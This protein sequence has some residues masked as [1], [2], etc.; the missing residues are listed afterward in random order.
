MPR[1]YVDLHFAPNWELIDPAR[2]FL[3][4]F[5]SITLRNEEIAGQVGLDP[6]TG[7]IVEGGVGAQARQVLANIS[8]VLGD[9]GASLTDVAK[10]TV[11]L[12]DMADFAKV[13]EVYTKHLGNSRPARSTVAVAGLPRGVR[14]VVLSEYGITPVRR[15]IAL[16]RVFRAR[17]WLTLKEELGRELLDCG[18]SRAFAIAE[19][20]RAKR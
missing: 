7:T 16:N 15:S 20:R 18:A 3:Q 11:F 12:A 5:F 4:K 6:A 13:N 17:G 9:C 1:A 8:A 2:E 14:V 19:G 10:S